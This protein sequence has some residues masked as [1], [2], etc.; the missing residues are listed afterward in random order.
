MYRA[1]T[2]GIRVTVRPL[3]LEDESDPDEDRYFWA[4]TVELL[5]LGVE[6]VQLRSRFWH[7]TDA[8]GRVQEVQGPGVVGE[9]PVLEPGESFEYTSGCPLTTPG[10]IM[11]GSYTMEAATGE[12][13]EV[14]IPAFSLDVPDTPRVLN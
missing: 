2:R 6:T 14:E 7:I 12:S 13:F 4:Y 10:G 5:N 8:L 3:Y 11:V 9:E 1:E